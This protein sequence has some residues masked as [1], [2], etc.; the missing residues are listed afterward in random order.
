MY[1]YTNVKGDS[2]DVNL[3][4][5]MGSFRKYFKES[6]LFEC[7]D[8]FSFSP[9]NDTLFMRDFFRDDYFLKQWEQQP[10]D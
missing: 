7:K 2:L 8:D 6:A 10:I 4:S 9:K 3:D 5:I 1:S